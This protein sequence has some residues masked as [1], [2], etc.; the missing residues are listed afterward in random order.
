MLD[1]KV[2]AGRLGLSEKSVRRKIASGEIGSYRFGKLV[3]VS[4]EQFAEYL[5]RSR[6]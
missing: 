3:R 4:D 5:A 6:R 2:V 1:V